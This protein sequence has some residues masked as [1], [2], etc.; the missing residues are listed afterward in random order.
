MRRIIAAVAVAVFGL[1]AGAAFAQGPADKVPAA[2]SHSDHRVCLRSY[3]IDRTEVV[4]ARTILF[5]M[6]DGKIWKNTLINYCPGLKY[7]GFS[8]SPVPSSNTICGNMQTIR[9]L[10]D[11]TVCAL[12]SFEPYTPPKR[13]HAE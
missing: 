13:R 11:G 3:M 10:R 12:G 1:A 9:V 4:D 5:Y 6:R 2:K 7:N 8:Y